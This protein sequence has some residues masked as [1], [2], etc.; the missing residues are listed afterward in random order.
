MNK[1]LIRFVSGTA[2]FGLLFALKAAAQDNKIGLMFEGFGLNTLQLSDTQYVGEC[3]GLEK[4]AVKTRFTDSQ[5]DTDKDLR[6]S[7]INKTDGV[8]AGNPP[9]KDTAYK[10]NGTSDSF[11]T[12]SSTRSGFGVINGINTI[13]YKI[14]N[15]KSKE[16]LGTGSLQVEAKTSVTTATRNGTWRG[17]TVACAIDS[18]NVQNCPEG[19]LILKAQK[20]CPDGRILDTSIR[21]FRK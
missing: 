16:T 7:L 17:E 19:R 10:K 6:V 5:V 21:P 20:V 18:S 4:G 9:K 13:E 11:S 2:V 15:K 8:D 14:Y 3:P 1:L 12:R